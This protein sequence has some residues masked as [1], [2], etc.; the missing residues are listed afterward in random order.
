MRRN[1]LPCSVATHDAFFVTVLRVAMQKQLQTPPFL[2]RSFG[3]LLA[4]TRLKTDT[5]L[6]VLGP[7]TE[8]N[9]DRLS[10]ETLPPQMRQRQCQ[11]YSY[12]LQ[13]CPLNRQRSKLR[14]QPCK[15]KYKRQRR[16][17][18]RLCLQQLHNLRS[19][20]RMRRHF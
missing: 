12:K 1:P 16:L 2:Q 8:S 7:E 19:Q 14:R 9:A 13:R 3:M 17:C 11:W 5:E 4:Q 15:H 6:L 10:Q 18:P 20:F